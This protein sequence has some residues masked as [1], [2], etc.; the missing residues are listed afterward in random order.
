MCLLHACFDLWFSVFI[1]I[2][3]WPV[4][5]VSRMLMLEPLTL[6]GGHEGK[7]RLIRHGKHAFCKSGWKTEGPQPGFGLKGCAIG[8][9]QMAMGPG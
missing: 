4:D 2:F 9:G 8:Y 7:M 1:F 3:L 5:F 6:G